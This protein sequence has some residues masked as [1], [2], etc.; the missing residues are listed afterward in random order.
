MTDEEFIAQMLS[1]RTKKPVVPEAPKND[2]I[3]SLKSSNLANPEVKASS[4]EVERSRPVGTAESHRKPL[5]GKQVGELKRVNV[6]GGGGEGDKKRWSSG[7]E[8][9]LPE[10]SKPSLSSEDDIEEPAEEEIVVRKKMVRGS[11]A[12]Q[13]RSGK[14][15][16]AKKQRTSLSMRRENSDDDFL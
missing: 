7:E 3:V 1:R 12:G 14:P 4:R 16:T 6:E 5:F 13:R 9:V 15:K 8:V 10:Q 11:Q 2:S